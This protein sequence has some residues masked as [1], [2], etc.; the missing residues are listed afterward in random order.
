MSNF[1]ASP[2]RRLLSGIAIDNGKLRV[3]PLTQDFVPGLNFFAVRYG[4]RLANLRE[5]PRPRY[6]STSVSSRIRST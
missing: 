5:F 4:L 6:R 3:L 1:S 2:L